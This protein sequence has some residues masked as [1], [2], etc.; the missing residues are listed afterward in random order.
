M[1]D[2]ADVEKANLVEVVRRAFTLHQFVR[3]LRRK[4]YAYQ[5]LTG[6]VKASAVVP[7][8]LREFNRSLSTTFVLPKPMTRDAAIVTVRNM[9]PLSMG[10][11][12]GGGGGNKGG[13]SRTGDGKTSTSTRHVA[14]KIVTAAELDDTARAR[15][16]RRRR[17]EHAKHNDALLREEKD[18]TKKTRKK[19]TDTDTLSFMA[20]TLCGVEADDFFTW[21][22]TCGGVSGESGVSH[23]G[24]ETSGAAST[25]LPWVGLGGKDSDDFDAVAT[26]QA[27]PKPPPGRKSL[28][29]N[30]VVFDGGGG[31]GNDDDDDGAA[32][33]DAADAVEAE[34]PKKVVT[35]RTRREVYPPY[36]RL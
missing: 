25:W 13:K 8:D 15:D 14:Y 4:V 28:R 26:T 3:T 30:T 17:M 23:N 1:N 22:P 12:V 9:K 7:T 31:K 2:L 21:M 11:S 5:Y 19:D 34:A 36:D 20:P 10:S 18:A 33:A 16:E 6:R 29:S 35:S 27:K 24:D 32:K